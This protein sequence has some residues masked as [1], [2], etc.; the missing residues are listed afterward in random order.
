MRRRWLAGLGIVLLVAVLAVL[1]FGLW[2]R[3]PA[4]AQTAVPAPASFDHATIRQ[5]ARLVAAG[6]CIECHTAAGGQSY[7]GGYPV[8]TPFGTI[9][10]S[11]ITPD[12]T[13]GIGHWS[14]PAF[15]RAM[16]QG[17]ARD[18]SHLYPAFP[19]THFTRISNGDARAIYAYLMT[20]P[21]VRDRVP[22]P[23]LPFPLN[24]RP[25]MA[26]WNLLFFHE[27]RFKPKPDR[28]AQW[29]RGAYLAGGLG[30][31]AACHS[32]RNIFGAENRREAYD[33]GQSEGWSAPALGRHSPA[34]LP[35][36]KDEL[37]T[38]LSNGF[39]PTHG[40]AMGPMAGVTRQLAKLPPADVRA[41]ATFVASLAP[42]PSA[43]A[44]VA[45]AAAARAAYHVTTATAVAGRGPAKTGA[46]IFAG[47]CASCHFEGGDQPFYRPVRLGLSSVVNEPDARDFVHIVMAGI[48]PPSGAAGRWMPPFGVAL[49]DRQI[50]LLAQY[51]RSHFSGKPGWT[52]IARA[53]SDARKEPGS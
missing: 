34:P 13:T 28:S 29:N 53:V 44:A 47:A 16:R 25:V 39:V 12:P 27:G 7:A 1:S 49:T 32:P 10:G 42:A 5:G 14:E 48:Q 15:V 23:Q 22:P 45:A 35:W 20:L 6:Y 46:A 3:R 26:G 9:Y 40:L 21:P 30:H 8:P 43:D 33:G 37:A 41:I 51:V 52:G 50:T 38:Y 17:I 31:C 2:A 24:V 19:Y 4:I 18:G 11:N 36:T